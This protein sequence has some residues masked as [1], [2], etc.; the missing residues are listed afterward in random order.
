M[1]GGVDVQGTRSTTERQGRGEVARAI[2]G[3]ILFLLLL[4]LWVYL[5]V[6]LWP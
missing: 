2:V 4:V 3:V 1:F 6:P 5:W